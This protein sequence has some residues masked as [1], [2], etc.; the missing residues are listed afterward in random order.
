MHPPYPSPKV[1]CWREPLGGENELIMLSCGGTIE[2]RL[3]LRPYSVLCAWKTVRD[4]FSV[5][6][7]KLVA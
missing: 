4:F 3:L 6:G 5:H 1:L 2:V 7:G